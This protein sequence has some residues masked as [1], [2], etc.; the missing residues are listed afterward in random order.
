MKR[1]YAKDGMK[2]CWSCGSLNVGIV[3]EK[4][5]ENYRFIVRCEDCGEQTLNCSTEK[6]AKDAWNRAYENTLV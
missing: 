2:T 6:Q 5:S 3:E 4:E 1:V